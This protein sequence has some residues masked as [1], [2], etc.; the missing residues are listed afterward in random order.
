MFTLRISLFALHCKAT[1][2]D[3]TVS[4][5]AA[6]L[7]ITPWGAHE[8]PVWGTRLATSSGLAAFPVFFNTAFGSIF[9]T[10]YVWFA[11]TGNRPEATS[12]KK[13]T[14]SWYVLRNFTRIK[15]HVMSYLLLSN[16]EEILSYNNRLSLRGIIL[17]DYKGKIIWGLTKILEAIEETRSN[18]SFRYQKEKSYDST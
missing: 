12:C 1:I 15:N 7:R 6:T 4:V 3:T 9:A 11:W 5:F 10:K 2:F 8:G 16:W 13:C 18:Y 17:M 14:F